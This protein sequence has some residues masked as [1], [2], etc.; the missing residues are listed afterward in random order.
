MRGSERLYAD[1]V[2]RRARTLGEEHPETL[3]SNFDLASVYLVLCKNSSPRVYA[4]SR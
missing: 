3:R 2:R 1:I 4:A